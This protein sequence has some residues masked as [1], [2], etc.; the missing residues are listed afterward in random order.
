MLGAV[1]FQDLLIGVTTI[2]TFIEETKVF[3]G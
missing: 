2:P 3:N 1:A